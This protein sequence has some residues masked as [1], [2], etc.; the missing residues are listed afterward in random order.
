MSQPWP[1]RLRRLCARLS[2]NLCPNG[3]YKF[4]SDH[5]EGVLARHL[6]FA[7]NFAGRSSAI[8]TCHYMYATA[9]EIGPWL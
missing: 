9:V 8:A 3:P 2:A 6:S 5:F 1:A 7:Y 4:S